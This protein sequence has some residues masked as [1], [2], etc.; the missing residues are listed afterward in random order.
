VAI[1]RVET[2]VIPFSVSAYSVSLVDTT[3]G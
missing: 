2:S 1:W 3:K